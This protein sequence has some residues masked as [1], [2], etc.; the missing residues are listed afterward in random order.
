MRLDLQ[1]CNLSRSTQASDIIQEILGSQL[2]IP[3]ATRWNS[4]YH[5]LERL[6]SFT[7]GGEGDLDEV[8]GRLDLPRFKEAEKTYISEYVMVL[9]PL[10]LDLLQSDETAYYGVLLPTIATLIEKLQKIK[11]ESKLQYCTPLVNALIGGVKQRFGYVF[12]SR[13]C[14]MATAC[15]PMFRMEYIVTEQKADTETGLREEVRRL[16]T[17]STSPT[18][19][20][21]E[22]PP[23]AM[24]HSVYLLLLF[25]GL[26][27]LCSCLSHRGGTEFR[28][29]DYKGQPD[30]DGGNEHCAAMIPSGMWNDQPCDSKKSF[31]CYDDNLILVREN[32]SWNE[33]L[34]F[35]RQQHGDLVSV[36]T[37]QVQHWVNRRA[38]SASTAHV[39]LGLRF[40]CA[41]QFWFWVSV[42]D[43][44]YENWAPG[45]ET[46]ECGH[47]GAVESGA[48]QQWVSLQETE[49]LNF[50][51]CKCGGI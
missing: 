1:E 16:Q 7:S 17:P 45:N 40:S 8:C 28:N 26:F 9:A 33:A 35:C 21:E 29:W 38:Q 25:S 49:Q 46:G 20:E 50:I 5:A 10:A 41:M 30:N 15:H 42:E 2:V 51:C 34:S 12:E 36:P 14:L 13:K 27:T 37:E 22:D 23:K 47:T 31:I 4:T 43:M 6:K 39:W 48:G 18:A 24:E 44:C 11:R 32:K 3:N 19:D